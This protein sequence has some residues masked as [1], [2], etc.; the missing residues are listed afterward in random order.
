M[1]AYMQLDR[2]S[3]RQTGREKYDS[4]CI[5]A[6]VEPHYISYLERTPRIPQ[7]SS[8]YCILLNDYTL[9]PYPNLPPKCHILGKPLG[10]F[11]YE[12]KRLLTSSNC[13]RMESIDPWWWA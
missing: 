9:T 8:H 4:L 3:D 7:E 5:K 2:G 13:T 6:P 10:I 12:W 1:Y 11:R